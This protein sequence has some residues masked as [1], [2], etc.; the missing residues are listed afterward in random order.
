MEKLARIYDSEILPV[1]SH[2][3]GRMLLR[4]I[5]IETGWQILDVACGTGYPAVEIIRRMPEGA[6]LI[7][8]DD[9]SAMLDIARK[10]VEEM[11]AKNVFFRSESAAPRLSFADEV[12]DMVVC[13]L[14]LSDFKD[15]QRAL[16]DFARVTKSGGE[17]RCTLPLLG[18]FGEFYD[19]Y[20][21]VLI[22]HDKHEILERLNEQMHSTFWSS[23]DCYAWLESAGLESA[24]VEIDEFTMLFRSSREFF[25]SPVIEFG[26]L[27]DWKRAAG[28]GQE[29]QDIFWYIKE[30][31]DAYYEGR[32]F[33][34]TVRAGMLKGTKPVGG[35]TQDIDLPELSESERS[36]DYVRPVLKID[37][38]VALDAFIDGAER[39]DHLDD[40]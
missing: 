29:M 33:E 34:V 22:K 40:D 27:S 28:R 2:R 7:A 9:S 15:P 8:I 12:Y 32:A 20:R 19:I 36:E 11:G 10:K 1:W 26:P 17:V 39:P 31:I 13:N 23:D 6:R 25:F 4:E 35:D 30:A 16:A 14:G 5:H 3:F 24:M 37:D 18:T 38:D 21:E